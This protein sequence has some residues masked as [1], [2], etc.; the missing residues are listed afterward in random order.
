[1]RK[2]LVSLFCAASMLL[3]LHNAAAQNVQFCKSYGSPT[4]WPGNAI[5]ET[6][7]NNLI[8]LS[9][10]RRIHT[11]GED[12]RDILLTKTNLSGDTLWTRTIGQETASELGNALN[13]LPDGKMI[14]S[15]YKESSFGQPINGILTLC[16]PN[17]NPIWERSFSENNNNCA[18]FS[19]SYVND[20]IVLVGM[21]EKNDSVNI[22]IVKTDF[23]GNIVWQKTIANSHINQATKILP[24]N[25]GGFL[26]SGTSNAPTNGEY[27]HAFV[28]KTDSLGGLIWDKY[29]SI[30]DAHLIAND[31][32]QA[33]SSDG[34]FDGYIL[35]GQK[36]SLNNGS[37]LLITKIDTLGN[38][39]WEREKQNEDPDMSLEGRSIIIEPGSGY[40][41]SG[42]GMYFDSLNNIFSSYLYYM[43]LDFDGNII[44]DLKYK[45]PFEMFYNVHAK[46]APNGANYLTGIVGHLPGAL[47]SNF[48][49][50]K[51]GNNNTSVSEPNKNLNSKIAA[52]PNPASDHIT[53]KLDYASPI[54]KVAIY[55]MQGRT[56]NCD[57]TKRRD[58]VKI[59]L[60]GLINQT[61][62]VEVDT[63]DGAKGRIKTIFQN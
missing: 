26:I 32:V 50:I 4:T 9:N 38:T 2:K 35:T 6:P 14:I 49:L 36:N 8:L 24:I 5:E 25:D 11:G 40:A 56:L 33:Y 23:D 63:E 10:F 17:G 29:F 27:Y 60:P 22:W 39:V 3:C 54:S 19:N 47:E 45:V 12:W 15:G 44:Q 52:Y 41:V 46:K 31:I 48:F 42:S 28:I 59:K 30:S 37:S 62:F 16:D 51:I 57:Y 58:E 53:I 43:T 21:I 18:F 13:I 7:D 61:L 1:M 55:D 20:G 34:T